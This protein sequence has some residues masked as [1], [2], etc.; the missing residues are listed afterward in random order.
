MNQKKAKGLRRAVRA[1]FDKDPTEVETDKRY[2]R[3]NL[4]KFGPGV[5]EH[6]ALHMN[7]GRAIYQR[8]K[9]AIRTGVLVADQFTAPRAVRRAEL[10][11]HHAA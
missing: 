2:H 6:R 1:A 10:E 3:H 11:M 4:A 9:K 7:C 8:L 5:F